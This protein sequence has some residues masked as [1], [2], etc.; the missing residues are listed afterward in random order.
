MRRFRFHIGT[1]LILIVF[2]GLAFAA[3]R[4]ANELWD[5]VVLSTVIGLLLI[6]VLLAA[7]R[8]E[9]KRAFWAA[10]AL[11]GWGY[12]GLTAI[13]SIESRLLTTKALGYLDSQIPGRPVVIKAWGG[14]VTNSGQTVTS[15]AFAPQGNV[16][17]STNRGGAVR[18]WAVNTG[19]L[20]FSA[21]GTSEDFV[22]IGHSLL[23]FILAWLGGKLSRRLH[24]R[25]RSMP[26][27]SGTL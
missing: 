17:A 4:E 10:F 18:L 23:A 26:P 2:L 11:F 7:H 27:E 5:S 21:G 9:E 20:L 3:L 13:P 24:L 1:V 16:L 22:R 25:N 8:K 6:S 14:P 15:V 12:I 19:K